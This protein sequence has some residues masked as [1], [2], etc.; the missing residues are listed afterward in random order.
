MAAGVG[1][2]PTSRASKARSLLEQPAMLAA[3]VRIE[4]TF[5][6]SEPVSFT[7]TTRIKTGACTVDSNP[8]RRLTR[9]LHSLCAMQAWG[10]RWESNPT[11]GD[12]QSPILPLNDDHQKFRARGAHG[13][14]RGFAPLQR[15]GWSA[16]RESNALISFCRRAPRPLGLRHKQNSRVG[17]MRPRIIE[18]LGSQHDRLPSTYPRQARQ[19]AYAWCLH[20]RET[21]TPRRI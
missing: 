15:L 1:F 2:A 12:S 11:L 7:R 16:A 9:A 3:G 19:G 8:D 6:G 21:G 5:T 4:L 14:A 10:D 17:F 13:P 20:Y 18:A